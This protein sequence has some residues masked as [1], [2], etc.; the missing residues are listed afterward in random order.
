M[1]HSQLTSRLLRFVKLRLARHN[2]GVPIHH[3]AH[4]H[5]A[6]VT[7]WVFPRIVRSR[8]KRIDDLICKS[9]SPRQLSSSSFL[10]ILG[11][12]LAP[13]PVLG[14]AVN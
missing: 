8:N 3:S 14:E 13:L 2:Y 4:G 10:I 12:L 5:M 11:G 9:Y 6:P 1:F 7:P